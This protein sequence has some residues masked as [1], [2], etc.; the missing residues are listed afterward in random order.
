MGQQRG[1]ETVRDRFWL[2]G[3]TAGSHDEEWNLPGPSLITPVEAANYLGIPNLLMIRYNGRPQM[4]YDQL[5]IPMRTLSRIGWGITGARG[6]TSTDEREHVLDLAS[7][8]PNISG[9][10]M[11]DFINWDTG[12]P[13]LTLADLRDLDQRRQLPDRTLDLM[14]ILYTHQLNIDISEH[15]EYCNQISLWTWHASDLSQLDA[16]MSR[17]EAIA[18]EHQRFVGC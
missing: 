18:P 6:E 17:L 7:R 14:T 4:P 8:T 16:N 10:V 11:D 1:P 12:E 13:E 15:L 3:H 9:L 5:T 2:W